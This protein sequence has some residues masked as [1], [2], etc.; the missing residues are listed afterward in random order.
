M[1]NVILIRYI[2]KGIK[3]LYYNYRYGKLA[4]D[5]YVYNLISK[6]MDYETESSGFT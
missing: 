6:E 2:F 4:I 3:A 1:T 5:I